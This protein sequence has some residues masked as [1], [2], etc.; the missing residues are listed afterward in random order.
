MINRIK[1]SLSARFNN[2]ISFLRDAHTNRHI[3]VIE[4]DDWGAIRIPSREVWEQMKELG[5]AVDKRPYE[6]Y[7]TLETDEDVI[8]LSNVLLKFKDSRGHHPV[9]T[10]NYL[11]VNPDFDAVAADSYKTYHYE[12]VANT[13]SKYPNSDNVISL[14]KKGI[15]QGIFMPQCHGR[16]HYNITDWLKALQSGDED[17]L[18]AFK[19]KMC[20]IFP[21]DNPSKGNQFMVALRAMDAKAKVFIATAVNESLEMFAQMWGMKSKTFVAPCYTWDSEIEEVLSRNDVELIQTARI[22]RHSMPTHLTYH[23]SGEKN[24]NGLVYSIRNCD[25]EPS[26]SCSSN[27]VDDCMAQIRIAFERSK[28][29]VISSHRINYVG[30]IDTERREENLKMLSILLDK[31]LTEFPDVEFMS[32]DMLCDIYK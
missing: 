10:L 22:Q 18:C 6:R 8:L 20:G 1:K 19:H 16:E 14:V 28:V 24:K 5:Y 4:S 25:F 9:I 11:S 7:D 13:Y 31:I 26:T 32:S 15:R 30:R 27:V 12:S 29:A 3:I 23:F 2:Y 17:V 21:K